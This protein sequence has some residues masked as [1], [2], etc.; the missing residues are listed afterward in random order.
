[1]LEKRKICKCFERRPLGNEETISLQANLPMTYRMHSE[2]FT[3]TILY[4]NKWPQRLKDN[5]VRART[6]N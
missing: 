3:F 5:G 2:A 4:L 1:M 6:I